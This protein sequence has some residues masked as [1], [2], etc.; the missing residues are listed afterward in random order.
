M[1]E[2][3]A[4]VAIDVGGTKIASGLFR[5]DGVCLFRNRMSTPQDSSEASLEL[6]VFLAA[7][8]AQALPSG[9]R[10]VAVGLVVP[11]W[12]KQRAGTVW[13]PN[14]KGWDHIPLRDVLQGRLPAPLRLE[15]DRTGYVAGEAWLG[16]AR[17]LED[18]VF[19]AVGTG[20]GAG[21]MVQGKILHGHDDLAGAVGWL[22]LN[23]QF[24]MHY[25]RM[26]CFEAEAS[27]NS[28]ARKAREYSDFFRNREITS[29]EVVKAAE[30]GD[31]MAARLLSEVGV[32]LGMGVANLVSTLNPQ[33]VVL[34]GGLFQN[35]N[36]LLKLV[37]EEFRRW[38]QPFAS[39]R[40]QLELSALGED[41]GLIGAARLAL[42]YSLNFNG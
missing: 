34:G 2:G 18:V 27:G 17:G 22:A 6:I 10:L 33:M 23:P 12:V 32:Y 1:P 11:G 8:A 21:I 19:L 29:R 15:S 42:D 40:V 26:G 30:A 7:E 5:E 41:A 3:R 20:I 14:I 16:A 38:A 9:H 31:E 39:E 24:Q 13:A 36:Y 4:V 28:V 35:G 25:A 37:R